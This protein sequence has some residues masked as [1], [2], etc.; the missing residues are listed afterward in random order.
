MF[1]PQNFITREVH[2][3]KQLHM[4]V[5]SALRSRNGVYT[6][7]SDTNQMGCFFNMYELSPNQKIFW[8]PPTDIKENKRNKKCICQ[9]S[10]NKLR[11]SRFEV[12]IAILIMLLVSLSIYQVLVVI[13]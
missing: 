8:T 9:H 5:K 13:T 1:V 3:D 12:Q 6:P 7:V 4:K 11:N 2:D 10:I